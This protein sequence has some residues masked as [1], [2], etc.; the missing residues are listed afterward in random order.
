MPTVLRPATPADA[1]AIHGVIAAGFATYRRF[2]PEGWEPPT[3]GPDRAG[4]RLDAPGAWGVV[5]VD[6]ARVVGVGAFEPARE[7]VIEGPLIPGLA[8]IWA[9]FVGESHWGSGVAIELLA[10][11]TTEIW[12]QGFA[13]AR[14]FTPAGQARARHFYARE[15]WRETTAPFLVPELGLELVELRRWP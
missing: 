5:A 12:T 6:S 9:I 11:T 8:H 10:A 3:Q 1:E 7:G 14:L 13:E 2:A 4:T 15:G